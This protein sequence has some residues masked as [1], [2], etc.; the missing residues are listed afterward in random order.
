MINQPEI[1]LIRTGAEMAVGSAPGS[2]G[3]S[4]RAFPFVCQTQ[5]QEFVSSAN[6]DTHSLTRRHTEGVDRPGLV[7]ASPT[8]NVSEPL[9]L[10]W[11]QGR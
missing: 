1:E 9:V 6:T 3:A 10:K 2:S 7:S 5:C 8:R 4:H 11:P